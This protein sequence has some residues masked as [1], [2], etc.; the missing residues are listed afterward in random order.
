MEPLPK[1]P[2]KDIMDYPARFQF[3]QVDAPCAGASCCT[4]T[5]IQ[6]IVEYYK[7]VTHSLGGIR[8]NAQRDTHFDERPC[9]GLNS[10]EVLNALENLGI[11]HYK[12]GKAV[13]AWDVWRK[14]DVGPVIVG[15]HYGSY[16]D[17]KGRCTNRN[18][19]RNGKTDC[20]FSG[21][22]AVLAVGKRVHRVPK[23]FHRDFYIRD[24]DHNSRARPEKPD[25]D[26]IRRKQ[27]DLAMK[28]IVPYTAFGSTYIIYPTKK[29]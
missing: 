8:R 5:C 9:T 27:L 6:M 14:L 23:D 4:D 13:D 10:V 1:K 3:G 18:A 28:N 12:V 24:P 15:V 11:K 22:H 17:E 19:E 26:I 29:K 25:Y 20:P 16:P 7:D 2:S 21:A